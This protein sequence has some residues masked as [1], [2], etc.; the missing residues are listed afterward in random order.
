MIAVHKLNILLLIICSSS[1]YHS[2]ATGILQRPIDSRTDLAR[3]TIPWPTLIP[4][5][6]IIRIPLPL[7]LPSVILILLL[8]P[9]PQPF[10]PKPNLI[11][12]PQLPIHPIPQ[13]IR[14]HPR[15]RIVRL[16]NQCK[17]HNEKA[18][19]EPAQ[20]ERPIIPGAPHIL[21]LVQ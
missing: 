6:M 9:I 13:P 15:I 4:P 1:L 20:E 19:A 5:I 8:Y 18:N 12:L 17:I 14:R 7:M 3:Q 21:R 16:G 10:R 11:P 2:S